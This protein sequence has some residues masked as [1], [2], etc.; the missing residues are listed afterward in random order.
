MT[1]CAPRSNRG[2]FTLIELLVVIGIMGALLVL[3]VPAFTGLGR[4]QSMRSSVSQL[5]ST[6]ALARQWAITKNENTYVI[7]PDDAM[8]YNPPGRVN[9]A[10]R[11]YGVWAE[12]SGYISEWRYLPP[13]VYFN[14][15]NLS[16]N[17]IFD[18]ASLTKHWVVFPANGS[19]RQEMYCIA[20]TP[21]GRLKS[22]QDGSSRS[23]YL[24]EGLLDVN[25]NAGLLVAAV[26][27]S[28]NYT[29]RFEVRPLT[30]QLRIREL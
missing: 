10:L 5:R 26:L 8:T 15:T 21:N 25:T 6:L 12:K 3:V 24:N 2:A 22:I 14:P 16:G 18:D 1:T 27:R 23:L 20:Y 13:G 30:G 9:M 7:F 19:P 29:M 28:T 4:G 11:S 17:N